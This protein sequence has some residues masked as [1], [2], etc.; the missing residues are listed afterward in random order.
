[1]KEIKNIIP[2]HKLVEDGFEEIINYVT[3]DG[4]IFPDKEL[5]KKHEQDIN[6]KEKFKL[7]RIKLYDGLY[8]LIYL[9]DI[10]DAKEISK[11][12]YG[13]RF[14]D[15]RIG[16]NFI[17]VEDGGDYPDSVYIY[18]LATMIEI[19]KSSA[20]EIQDNLKKLES[21]KNLEV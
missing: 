11:R 15:L 6:F 2:K 17:Q 9:S 5:A 12:Y 21:F 4:L 20:K 1:M 3:T 16:Y 13:E 10:N 8:D 19:L 14:Q 7:Q 18:P